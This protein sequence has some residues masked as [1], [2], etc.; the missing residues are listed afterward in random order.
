MFPQKSTFQIWHVI[1]KSNPVET[2]ENWITEKV[3]ILR[4]GLS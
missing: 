4:N 1:L 3:I 2:A